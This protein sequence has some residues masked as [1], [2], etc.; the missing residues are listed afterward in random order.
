MFLYLEVQYAPRS[1]RPFSP[2]PMVEV[3]LFPLVAAFQPLTTS[4]LHR[5]L[6]SKYPQGDMLP[7]RDHM[8]VPHVIL[9][10]SRFLFLFFILHREAVAIIFRDASVTYLHVGNTYDPSITKHSPRTLSPPLRAADLYF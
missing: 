3:H 4:R 1:L 6:L 10:D 2:S 8:Y 5:Y 9:H 7:I